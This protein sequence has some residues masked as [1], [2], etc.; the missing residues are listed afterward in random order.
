MGWVLWYSLL[1]WRKVIT[2]GYWRNFNF[3][4]FIHKLPGIEP[5]N[6]AAEVGRA[7]PKCIL[8]YY[9]SYHLIRLHIRIIT[10]YLFTF[11][12]KPFGFHVLYVRINSSY[13][14]QS[15]KTT[16]FLT[17][18]SLLNIR[19]GNYISWIFNCDGNYISSIFVTKTIALKY[20]WRK[21]YLLN[22]HDGNHNSLDHS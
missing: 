21:L 6:E 7:E 15:F 10:I 1:H 12:S 9:G 4:N 19:D 14:A 17:E 20:L 8:L 3:I 11:F 13:M 16:I 5:A 18:T 2:P 22:I